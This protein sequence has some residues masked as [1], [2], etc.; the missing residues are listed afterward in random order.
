MTRSTRLVL[1]LVCWLAASLSL[2]ALVFATPAKAAN[3]DILA[4]EAVT[5]DR[6]VLPESVT[7][8][9]ADRRLK[10]LAELSAE[11]RLEA[12]TYE[13]DGLRVKGYLAIPKAGENLPSVI[14]NRG[15]NRDFGAL[16]PYRAALLLGRLARHGYVVAASQY[17]GVDGGEGM[18]EFGGAELADILNLLPLL[19]SLPEADATRVGIYGWS[20]GG[21]MTYQALAATDRFKAAVVGAGPSDIAATIEHRPVMEE[22]VLAEL[23][24]NWKETREAAIAHRSAIRWPEKLSATTPILLLH[25]TGDW[26]VD[27]TQSLNMATALYEAKR[28]YRLMV[29]EGGDHGL[30]EFRDEVDEVVAAWFDR[31]VRDGE[32]WPSLEPHGR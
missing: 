30:S 21:M 14:F 1:G 23:V 32:S 18:E 19:E 22:R 31:F 28:P 8:E 26:R 15:G 4:R 20:R 7:G 13:S 6:S 24:P 17:R 25:G 11:V 9:D 16:S 10:A 5:L 3:G 12:L 29:F 27:V 2:V